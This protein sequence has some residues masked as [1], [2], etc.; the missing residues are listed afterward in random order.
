MSQQKPLSAAGGLALLAVSWLTIMVGSVI[1]PGLR[2]IAD[3][4]GVPGHAASWLV[5][6]PSLG[7]VLF[8]P[9][10][11]WSITRFG[12]RLALR[13]GL[14]AY[15]CLGVACV[16]LHGVW[17]AFAD[18]L[19]LG[20]AT[21]VTMAAGT[22]AIA[23]YYEGPARLH[24]MARQGMAIK[25]GGVV[26]LSLGGLLAGAG[27]QW[28]FALYAFAFVCLIFVEITLPRPEPTA[29]RSMEDVGPT[30]SR[31]RWHGDI[32]LAALLSMLIFFVAIVT[33]PQRLHQLDLTDVT[34]GYFLS[35]VAVV[36]VVT[37]LVMPQVMHRLGEQGTLM[38]GFTCYALSHLLFAAWD[39]ISGAMLGGVLLGS[40]CGFTVPLLNHM[41][42]ERSTL[43]SHGTNLSNLSM[44]LFLGQ[45]L[46]SFVR[47]LPGG[48]T[49]AFLVAAGLG[50]VGFVV[51]AA[52][53]RRERR[54]GAS[55]P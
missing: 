44:A 12:A 40:A 4:L 47:S 22:S 34:T 33:L 30:P 35:A 6:L 15:G 1:V 50:V 29:S 2:H 20:G 36:G 51:T 38:L 26:F 18:R 17:A 45:F 24:M 28:P 7:V 42:V 25:L 54:L 48:P 32:Y 31:R 9:L 3:G 53:A 46:A 13:A 41:M 21:A 11:G 14:I 37:S 52:S 39:A 49:M 27:W 10:A 55:T 23:L 19:L 16:A 5:T 43:A 8:A